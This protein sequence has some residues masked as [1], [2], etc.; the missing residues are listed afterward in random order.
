MDDWE[1]RLDDALA[2]LEDFNYLNVNDVSKED[3]MFYVECMVEMADR[4]RPMRDKYSEQIA[5][6]YAAYEFADSAVTGFQAYLNGD[7]YE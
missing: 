7:D 4:L 5:D 6:N 2:V 1:N 3:R